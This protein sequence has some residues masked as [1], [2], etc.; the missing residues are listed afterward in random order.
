M[1]NCQITRGIFPKKNVIWDFRYLPW[2]FQYILYPFKGFPCFGRK[3]K[4]ELSK[5]KLCL[6]VIGSENPREFLWGKSPNQIDGFPA[7]P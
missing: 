6:L 5:S 7:F 2:H 4:N 1:A 3:M